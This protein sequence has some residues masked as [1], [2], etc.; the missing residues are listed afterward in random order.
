VGIVF[1]KK[2]LKPFICIDTNCN[3]VERHVNDHGMTWHEWL[4]LFGVVM[5]LEGVWLFIIILYLTMCVKWAY[6]WYLIAM[7]C[8]EGVFTHWACG[9]SSY[10]PLIFPGQNSKVSVWTAWAR[11]HI[12]LVEC[13]DSTGCAWEFSFS[14]VV[15]VCEHFMHVIHL[16]KM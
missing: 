15:N 2:W 11:G 1:E 8:F 10:F 7:F 9:S 13:Q 12:C 6:H 5:S 14:L 3:W 16:F 4:D